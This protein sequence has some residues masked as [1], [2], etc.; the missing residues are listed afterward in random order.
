MG[1]SAGKWIKT[2]LFGKKHSKSNYSKN[3]TPDKKTAV[4]TPVEDTARDSS[5]IPD[6]VTERGAEILE[7]EKGTSGS[8]CDGGG[9]AYVDQGIDSPN[10]NE[11]VPVSDEERRRQEQ[12][13]T[14]AQASF[15]GYLARRA[16]RA[17]KGIIRLQ[18][19]IRGHLVRRQAVATLHSMHA[20]VKFQALA[21]GR[22]VRLSE[23]IPE[24]MKNFNMGGLQVATGA[25][26]TPFI[27]SEKL[28][29]HPFIRK[30]LVILPT[31]MP[32]SLQYDLAEPN[33]AW[34]WL[35]RWT[36][37]RFWEAPARTKKPMKVKPQRKLESEHVKSKR[38]IR[39]VSATA[40]G[41]NGGAASSEMDKP[42][43][44]PRKVTGQTEVVQE[45]NQSELE[46]VKRS[47][48]KVSASTVA[49]PEKPDPETEKPHPL[50]SVEIVTSPAPPD[51]FEQE[52]VISPENPGDSDVVVDK[53]DSADSIEVAEKA[54]KDEPIDVQ[55][56]S[57]PVVEAPSFENGVKM[58]SALSLDDES[59]C[60]EEQSRKEN[61]KTRKRRS[62]P[63]K[64][65]Y[66]EN[67]SQNS[68]SLPSYMAAT[69]S[70]KA[71]LRAQGSTKLVEDEIDYGNARRHS[72][73]ASTNGKLS[74]L[75]PR[76]QKPVLANGKGSKVNK[77]M[78]SSRDD[79]VVQPGWRR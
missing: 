52:V 69:E 6:Q 44:I 48:R 8:Q 13:A 73:P 29:G 40:H 75:S 14:K 49:A 43:R 25:H 58:E 45:Q 3:V 51:V 4:K 64:Q 68:P 54:I 63:A 50:P 36:L 12:A 19:L 72:L 78:T 5:F 39:K 21:R 11:L 66:T 34:N 23:F 53:P 9:V 41:E 1:K 30:L 17:L 60:K 20:I 59:S 37:S 33:A 22:R 42:K 79:K 27:G 10:N 62:L 7:L 26:S 70:A 35:E 71:K 47:L 31:A 24:V 38:T 57:H 18:A 67:I 28:A 56:E 15:R 16:F 55:H 65:D 46:R 2:V 32:L 74:S 76:I 77:S 61:P